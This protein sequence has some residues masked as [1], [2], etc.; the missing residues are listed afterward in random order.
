M[1]RSSGKHSKQ[2]RNLTAKKRLPPSKFLKEFKEGQSVLIDVNPMFGKSEPHLRFNHRTGKV[3]GKRGKSFVVVIKDGNKE[4][5]LY[6]PV[7][8]LKAC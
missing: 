1:K 5:E 7:V 2:S 6:L 3:V 4:K 8:H